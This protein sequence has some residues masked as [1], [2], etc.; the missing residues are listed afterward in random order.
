VDVTGSAGVSAVGDGIIK[1]SVGIT[2][3]GLSAT[4]YSNDVGIKTYV[5]LLVNGLFASGEVGSVFI[6]GLVY[7]NQTPDWMSISD[8]NT[9]SWSSINDANI[10][11]WTEI[12]NS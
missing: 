8:T 12:T 9:P 11:N 7:T 4:G 1:T 5:N 6:W 2:P 10:P 3:A